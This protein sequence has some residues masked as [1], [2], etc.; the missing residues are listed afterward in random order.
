LF[1]IIVLRHPKGSS[2]QGPVCTDGVVPRAFLSCCQRRVVEDDCSKTARSPCKLS[3]HVARSSPGCVGKTGFLLGGRGSTNLATTVATSGPSPEGCRI[4]A[5]CVGRL[6]V[7]PC[8][9]CGLPT[10]KPSLIF[11]RIAVNT[12]GRTTARRNVENQCLTTVMSN[13]S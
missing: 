4:P 5:W 13:I 10:P 12:I 1:V 9:G 6:L 11:D 8:T 7:R 2:T 3:W